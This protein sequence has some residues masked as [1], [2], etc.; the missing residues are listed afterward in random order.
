MEISQK[1]VASSEYM[2][3]NSRS[4]KYVRDYLSQVRWQQRSSRRPALGSENYR[5]NTYI[6]SLVPLLTLI[7]SARKAGLVVPYTGLLKEQ[8][9]LWRSRMIDATSRGTHSKSKFS[10]VSLVGYPKLTLRV[11]DIFIEINRSWTKLLWPR[12]G[13]KSINQKF[14]QFLY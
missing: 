12:V 10:M 4:W 6:T 11:S 13:G 2:N 8:R 1:F 9:N 3:F 7:Y 14:I 5:T